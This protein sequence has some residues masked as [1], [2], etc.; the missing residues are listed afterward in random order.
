MN[1]KRLDHP[2]CHLLLIAALGLLA[3]ANSL[4][5]PM[6]FDDLESIV[7]NETIRDLGNFLPGGSGLDFHF[8]R[9]VAYF[10][11]ALNYRLGGH[12]VTG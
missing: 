11:F 12:A 1:R 3:Y 9:W 2:L 5:G 4:G 8:R 6:V 7:R 10:S